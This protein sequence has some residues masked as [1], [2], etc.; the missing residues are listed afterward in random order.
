M[1]STEVA[2]LRIYDAKQ[3]AIAPV[4]ESD[5]TTRGM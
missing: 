2:Y 5:G 3:D 1:Q 4:R